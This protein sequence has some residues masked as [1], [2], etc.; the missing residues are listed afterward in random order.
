MTDLFGNTGGQITKGAMSR[1]NTVI[2]HWQEMAWN[3]V[4]RQK[5]EFFGDILN[6]LANRVHDALWEMGDGNVVQHLVEQKL[7]NDPDLA[8]LAF[9]HDVR[10]YVG[11]KLLVLANI[12]LMAENSPWTQ[13][14]NLFEK[15]EDLHSLS[16]KHLSWDQKLDRTHVDSANYYGSIIGVSKRFALQN[17]GQGTL[18]AHDLN[19]IDGSVQVDQKYKIKYGNGQ[20]IAELQ[21]EAAR[22]QARAY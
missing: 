21:N 17:T 14:T 7:I 3:G 12:I 4:R 11:S 22:I 5:G 20:G 8:K 18:I 10:R 6:P 13:H 2:E 1:A 9:H 15:F 19:L 16:C